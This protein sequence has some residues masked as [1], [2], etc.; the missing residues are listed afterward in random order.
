MKLRLMP[1]SLFGRLLGALL[2]AVG[3]TLVVVVL[4]IVRERRDLLFWGGE[5]AAI[6]NAIA[7]TSTALAALPA[8]ARAAELARLHAAPVVLARAASAR[9]P[10]S[11]PEDVAAAS[12][13]LAQRLERELGDAY[14]VT[15]Q[16]ARP[17]PPGDSIRVQS[18]PRRESFGGGGGPGSG[19]GGPRPPPPDDRTSPSSSG[20][21]PPAGPG[22]GRGFEPDRGFGGGGGPRPNDRFGGPGPREL[23]VSVALPD[24]FVVPF[25]TDVPRAGPPLPRQ[26]FVELLALT[27]VLGAVL[28][29][30]ARTITRPLTRLASA[31]DAIGRGERAQAL[32]ETGARELR[33]ATRA[34]NAMQERLHRYLDS[35]TQVLAAMSHDLRTPLTRLRLRVESLDEPQRDRFVADLDEM[36]R[37]VTGALNLFR[38]MNDDEQPQPVSIEA[39]LDELRAEFAELGG[40]LSVSGAASGAI[41]AKPLALKRCLTNLISNAVKYGTRAA[42]TIEDGP[43]E[44]VLTVADEGPGIPE[45]MLERVFEP[46]FRLEGSRNAATGGTGLGLSIARDIAQAHGGSLVLRN[47]TPRG[48]EAT[49]RL[50]RASS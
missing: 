33:E 27:L 36:N 48:L 50:P 37:M 10:P 25:R 13:S 2:A 41:V 3:V 9:L 32:D 5:S 30:M 12:R 19:P 24:G 20:G 45:D 43:A 35:R 4:L 47:R 14:R 22:P 15:V 18:Q 46:F 31:A 34:F 7:E 11:R 44:L 49:L 21:S 6:V 40:E 29:L 23:D 1:D 38:G 16:P 39:L 8:D 28:Y 42:V 26:I 17:G